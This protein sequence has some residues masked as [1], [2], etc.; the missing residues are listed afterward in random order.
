MRD[1]QQENALTQWR[2]DPMRAPLIR[3]CE[4]RLVSQTMTELLDR[5]RQV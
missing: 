4:D 1:D 2:R 5:T 3:A